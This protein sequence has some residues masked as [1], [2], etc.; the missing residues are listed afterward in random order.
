MR[1]RAVHELSR[2]VIWPD[3][4]SPSLRTTGTPLTVRS[5]WCATVSVLPIDTATRWLEPVPPDRL[6]MPGLRLLSAAVHLARDYTDAS[7]DCL[8]DA[9]ADDSRARGDANAEMVA[10]SLGTLAA[11]SRCDVARLLALASCSASVPGAHGHPIVRLGHGTIAAVV[12]EMS[13]N[14]EAALEAFAETPLDD[15]PRALALLPNRFLM[16]CLL[17]SGRADEAVEV[18]DRILATGSHQHMEQMPVFTRW[19]A[20][21]P[22]PSSSIT[23]SIPTPTRRA[24][25]ALGTPSWP[26]RSKQ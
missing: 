18:A 13:G 12:A 6:T 21:D 19:L 17:L 15:V 14:P 25:P 2:A 16:H 24:A 11:Q 23:A 1:A 26:R 7:V 22:S 5:N 20:G 3:R 9:A 8:I 10:L 4:R